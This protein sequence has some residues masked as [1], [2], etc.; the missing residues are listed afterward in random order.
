MSQKKGGE[1]RRRKR[2]HL[3]RVQNGLCYWCEQPTR[4]VYRVPPGEQPDDVATLEHLDDKLEPMRGKR[5]HEGPRIVMACHGCNNRRAK[6]RVASLPIEELH[7]RAQGGK[8]GPVSP[9]LT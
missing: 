8:R 1:Y 4:L 5:A 9:S 2:A 3:H 7:A 6:K